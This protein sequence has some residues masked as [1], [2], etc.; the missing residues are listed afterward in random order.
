M[1]YCVDKVSQD[2]LMDRQPVN[3]I[4]PATEIQEYPS[5]QWYCAMDHTAVTDSPD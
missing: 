5:M 1:K 4:P 3:I 2:A